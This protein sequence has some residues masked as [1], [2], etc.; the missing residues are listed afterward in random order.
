MGVPV[1]DVLEWMRDATAEYPNPASSVVTRGTEGLIGDDGARIGVLEDG[2]TPAAGFVGN[3]TESGTGAA[4]LASEPGFTRGCPAN[5]MIP[6]ADTK[7]DT[8]LAT[9]PGAAQGTSLRA[10]DGIVNHGDLPGRAKIVDSNVCD[11]TSQTRSVR[12]ARLRAHEL[13]H[14]NRRKDEFL[15]ILGHE[16]RSPLGA[17]QTAVYLLDSLTAE[18]PAR[19]RAQALIERQIRRMTQLVDDLLDVSRINHGRLHL[20][21]E[22][23][24]LRVVA[25]NAIETLESDINERHQQL[26]TALPDAPVWLRADPWRL[27]QVFVNLL[28]NA[29]KYTDSGGVLELSVHTREGQ[30][31]VRI[32][33]SGIGIS[34]E[35]L[36]HIFDLFRQGD[37]AVPRSKSGLG[38]GLALVR[39]LVEL[40]GGSVTAASAGSERGSEFTE[41]G[42]AHV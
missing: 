4:L 2:Q 6:I 36:P 41:I 30:A 16:L 34:P 14:V 15:A 19:Q 20:E 11:I 8:V 24:D 9:L 32:R 27:E 29:S 12:H 17:I 5:D 18:A 22:R 21:R 33:D 37:D 35:A 25:S 23:I 40:H 7:S 26:I 10:D 1:R 13:A 3:G 38:I 39:T 28:S 42:R 31:V